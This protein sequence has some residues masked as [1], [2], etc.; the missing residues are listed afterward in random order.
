M[1]DHEGWYFALNRLE[2]LAIKGV[3]IQEVPSHHHSC[4]EP[5]IQALAVESLLR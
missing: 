1:K 3:E 4:C 2:L 5:Q